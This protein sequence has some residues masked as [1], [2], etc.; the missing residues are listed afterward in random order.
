MIEADGTRWCQRAGSH[1]TD[2]VVLDVT[3]DFMW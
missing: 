2:T 3:L 1:L